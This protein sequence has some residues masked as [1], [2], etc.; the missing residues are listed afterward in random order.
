MTCA[1]C[2][3]RIERGLEKLDGVEASV[4][5]A[6]EQAAVT[7]DPARVALADLVE[8]VEAAGYRAWP[9]DGAREREDR[10]PALRRSLLLAVALSVP[11]TALSIIPALQFEGWEWLALALAT[12]VVLWAGRDF[13]LAAAETRAI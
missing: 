11:L 6:T 5:Y 9:L 13:H 7:F 1:A 10:A 8:A 3:A 12:P 4:N 2:A